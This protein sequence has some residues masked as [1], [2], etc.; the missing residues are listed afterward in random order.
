MLQ[1][2]KDG[3]DARDLLVS[4]E[5]VGLFELDFLSFRIGHEVRADISTVEFHALDELNLVVQGFA[6]AHGDGAM[7]TDALHEFSDQFSDLLVTVGR[8]GG[9]ILDHLLGL[10][11]LGTS[12]EVLNDGFDGKVNAPAEIHGL[13]FVRES[14][15][16]PAATLLTPSRKMALARTV[17][18]VVPS[19]ASSLVLEATCLTS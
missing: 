11:R 7:L 19:P 13:R 1:Q 17:A 2:S 3:L 9:N 8:D 5:D 6:V 15:F 16:I 18:V 10:N 4:D 12:L 14:T